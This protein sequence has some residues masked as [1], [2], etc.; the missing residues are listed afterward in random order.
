MESAILAKDS[1][2][3][4]SEAL[5]IVKSKYQPKPKFIKSTVEPSKGMFR[6]KFTTDEART[7]NLKNNI[8]NDEVGHGLSQMSENYNIMKKMYPEA[9]PRELID[10]TTLMWNSPGKVKNKEL[11]DFFLFGNNNPDPNK[12]K[13]DYLTKVK[14]QR[15]KLIDIQP[16]SVED[17]IELFR[18]GNY[19]EIQ[20]QPGG[21][22]VKKGPGPFLI[23]E[24]RPQFKSMPVPNRQDPRFMA[25]QDSVIQN[26]KSIQALQDFNKAYNA[27][28]PYVATPENLTDDYKNSG[29]KQQAKYTNPKNTKNYLQPSK[30]IDDLNEEQRTNLIEAF[31]TQQ[32][33]T[34][35]N[36]PT[37]LYYGDLFNNSTYRNEDIWFDYHTNPVQPYHVEPMELVQSKT[38]GPL[39]TSFERPAPGVPQVVP[40]TPTGK[41]FSPKTEGLTVPVPTIEVSREV[42]PPRSNQLFR[43]NVVN[44]KQRVKTNVKVDIDQ[45]EIMD[46]AKLDSLRE[47][48]GLEPKGYQFGGQPIKK[49]DGKYNMQRAIELG[50]EPDER[51]HWPSV[52]YTNGMWLKSKDHP[53][54]W[55]EYLYGHTLNPELNRTTNVVVNPQGHFGNNQLQYIPKKQLGGKT[56]PPDFNKKVSQ[57]DSVANMAFNTFTWERNAGSTKGEPLIDFGYHDSQEPVSRRP[58]DFTPPTNQKEAVDVY[59]KEIAPKVSYLPTAMEQASAGDFL[60]NT[61]RDP[62]VYLLDQYL[63]SIGQPGLPNRTDYNKDTKTDDWTPELQQGL[64]AEWNK[65]K[66]DIFKLPTQERRVMINNGRDY[67]YKNSYTADAPGVTYWSRSHDKKPGSVYDSETGY[68]YHRGPDGTLSPAY[69]N[70]WYG[71][72]RA[73]DQYEYVDPKVVNNK[74]GRY[75][76][77]KQTGGKNTKT[78]KLSSGKIITFK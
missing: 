69:A 59:M 7:S 45:R 71:R 37:A 48:M 61:G 9:T 68:W 2:I 21:Q 65:Y 14:N 58:V 28:Q 4:F 22:A 16:K 62:R 6:Q 67:Y 5:S 25:Y 64:D 35:I 52:D 40:Y 15:N 3:P 30:K 60:L 54:A 74:S 20:Y 13:F 43:K 39:S 11:V 18:N 49:D 47:S 8:F 75:Y 57:R 1:N 55:M 42:A 76:P 77:K 26:N 41:G 29:V 31:D 72:Q 19:P 78:I 27:K 23:P 38:P 51:G 56:L 46:R 44:P 17:H 66:K 10:L 33:G 50:Y 53:T 63:K 70:T 32:E 34:P 73:S 36:L 12:F 24:A